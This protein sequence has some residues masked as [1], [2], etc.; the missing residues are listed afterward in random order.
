MR[1]APFLLRTFVESHFFQLL[2]AVLVVLTVGFA[3]GE[4][5]SGVKG[6]I[7]DK[8]E[9]AP[10]RN[11]FVL[12][13]NNMGNDIHTRTDRKG[14]YMIQLPPGV[15]D[16]LVSASGFS[17]ACRKI[18]VDGNEM[19]KFDLVLEVNTLGMQVD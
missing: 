9:H 2:C 11:A 4:N 14:T 5:H 3:H 17:P 15:Y 19:T 7:V 12:V 6:R 1:N 10:I 16:V 8:F 13:H 18:E